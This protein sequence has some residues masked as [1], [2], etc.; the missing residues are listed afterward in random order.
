VRARC[1]VQCVTWRQRCAG[2]HP[3]SNVVKFPSGKSSFISNPWT[4][5]PN[6]EIQAVVTNPCVQWTNGQAVCW[7][8]THKD[9]TIATH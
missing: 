4:L 3:K 7:T 1:H 5:D 6:D 8:G 2:E 9:T